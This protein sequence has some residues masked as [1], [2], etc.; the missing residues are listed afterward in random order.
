MALGDKSFPF[1]GGPRLALG[2]PP[3]PRRSST[4]AATAAAAT[5]VATPVEPTT[6]KLISARWSAGSDGWFRLECEYAAS[7]PCDYLGISFDLPEA[8]VKSSTWLGAGPYRVWQNRLE[9]PTLGLWSCDAND[10]ITGWT[11]WKY[12]E[13]NG[14]FADLH[15][16]RIVT[17]AGTLTIA[18]ETRGLY[19]QRFTPKLPPNRLARTAWA[20]F[21]EAGISLLNAIP[22]IGSK[23]GAADQT[24]PQGQRFRAQ[25]TY[26][27]VVWFRVEAP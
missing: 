25:G 18:P 19:L 12:P 21:P 7:G 13:F 17:D 15:W 10:T 3:P 11:E 6:G 16:T 1:T 9:G 26:R 2:T 8:G 23:F 24:G 5:A 22:A 27:M 14:Y 20:P 4:T